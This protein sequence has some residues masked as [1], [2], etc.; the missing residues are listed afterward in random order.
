VGVTAGEGDFGK[1]DVVSICDESGIEIARGL[2]NYG[3][4]E[5]ARLRGLQS[6][7]IA[8]LLGCAAYPELV[9]RDNLVVVG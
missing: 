9:H 5:A 8:G 3:S 4:E 2:C 6:E 7:Q 1:G